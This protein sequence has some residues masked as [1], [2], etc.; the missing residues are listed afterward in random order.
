M[1]SIMPHAHSGALVDSSARV[2]QVVSGDK[3]YCMLSIRAEGIDVEFFLPDEAL[4]MAQVAADALN[5]AFAL[6]A[7]KEPADA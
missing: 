2:R 5:D 7:K 4:P 6:A 3:R 1:A